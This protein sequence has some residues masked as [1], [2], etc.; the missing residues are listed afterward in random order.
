M[1]A[2]VLFGGDSAELTSEGKEFLNKFLKA[3]TSI[4]YK[5]NMTVL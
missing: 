1:D 3:Y 5:K 4:I 2:T